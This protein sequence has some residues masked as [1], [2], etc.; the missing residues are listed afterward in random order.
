MPSS[1]NKF[2]LLDLD[3]FI[4]STLLI[5]IDP[6]SGFNNP[7]IFF[8]STDLIQLLLEKNLKITSFP[9]HNYWL[10]IGK[11]SDFLK[12]KNDINHIKF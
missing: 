8:N 2:S 10:D 9:M 12:A 11:H 6:I 7:I 1:N 3:K 4:V 5:F